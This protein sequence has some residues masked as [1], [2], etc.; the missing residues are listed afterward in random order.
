MRCRLKSVPGN[1]L[2]GK[3]ERMTSPPTE[4]LRSFARIMRQARELRGWTLSDLAQASQLDEKQLRA[5]ESGGR[6]PTLAQ[7]VALGNGLDLDPGDL[8]ALTLRET[9]FGTR[10]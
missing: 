4:L 1:G 6:S 7:L 8:V 10:K 3:F 5:L 9:R 2:A